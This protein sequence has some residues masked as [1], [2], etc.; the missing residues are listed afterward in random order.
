MPAFF[1]F[2]FFLVFSV[3]FTRVFSVSFISMKSLFSPSL[4][5]SSL[6]A[7]VPVEAFEML[8]GYVQV[9]KES[10]LIWMA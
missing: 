4:H 3:L 8:R 1:T 9:I 2:F 10:A 5:E 6:M 7:E